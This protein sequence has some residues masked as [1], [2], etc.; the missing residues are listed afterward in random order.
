MK[1]ETEYPFNEYKG[2][3]LTNKE[4]RRLV[5]LKHN[6][7]NEKLTI[8]YARYLMSVH[9]K[10][11]LEKDEH[12]DHIDGDRLND[13]IENLQ[14]LS[15]SENNR[16]SRIDNNLSRKMVEMKCPACDIIFSKNFNHSFIQKK[17][18]YNACSKECSYKINTFKYNKEQLKALGENQ[19]I[20]FYKKFN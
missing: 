18:L 16:K 3:L 12:V 13:I 14:I 5:C 8:S 1:I 10:R 15:P 9:L 4:P 2:Y 17:G 19:I 7:T 11:I 20:R 6:E